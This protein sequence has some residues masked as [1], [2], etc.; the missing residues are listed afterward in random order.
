MVKSKDVI[1]DRLYLWIRKGRGY[2]TS[3]FRTRLVSIA[4]AR[5]ER[6]TQV[7]KKPVWFGEKILPILRGDFLGTYGKFGELYEFNKLWK[8]KNVEGYQYQRFVLARRIIS[9]IFS[10][11]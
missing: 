3:G 1:K 11:E 5:V 10:P 7:D 6:V 9:G 4:I 8:Y 2:T